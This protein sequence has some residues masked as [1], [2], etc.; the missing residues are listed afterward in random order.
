MKISVQ[1]A[2]ARAAAALLLGCA[3]TV[4]ATSA[5]AQQSLARGVTMSEMSAMKQP[6]GNITTLHATAVNNSGQAIPLLSVRFEL[7]DAANKMVGEATASQANVA[8]GETWKIAVDTPVQF[9]RFT[10]MNVDAQP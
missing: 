6:D 7:Y 9:T 8:A 3:G 1:H 4:M 10:V 2:L 5:H